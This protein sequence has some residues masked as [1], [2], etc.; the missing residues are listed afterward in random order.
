MEVPDYS[1]FT[2]GELAQLLKARDLENK[3]L[4]AKVQV[5]ERHQ[6]LAYTMLT[7]RRDALTSKPP[8]GDLCTSS[9]RKKPPEKSKGMTGDAR[10]GKSCPATPAAGGLKARSR[11]SC[12]R[13]VRKQPNMIPKSVTAACGITLTAPGDVR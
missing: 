8:K 7:K 11:H 5:S 9:S 10:T 6:V 3:M 4:R 2:A 13:F 12:K 1:K